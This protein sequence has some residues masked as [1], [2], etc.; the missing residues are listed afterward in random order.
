MVDTTWYGGYYTEP[1][2]QQT[3]QWATA[4]IPQAAYDPYAQHDVHLPYPPLD[5]YA[6]PTYEPYPA[7][8]Q[9]PQQEQYYGQPYAEQ[10]YPQQP[11]GEQHYAGQPYAEHPHPPYAEQAHY[12]AYPHEAP[13]A[14]LAYQ[15][16]PASGHD[17]DG[18]RA[19]HTEYADHAFDDD[20]THD[21]DPALDALAGVDADPDAEHAPA[22]HDPLPPRESA[23]PEDAV[24]G[25]PA[26]PGGRAAARAARSRPSRRRSTI[27]AIAVPSVALLGIAGAAAA[28]L[29]PISSA[30]TRPVA[31]GPSAADRKAQALAAAQATAAAQQASRD[32]ARQA[33][34]LSTAAAKKK[35][36]EAPR[37]VLPITEHTGLS[38]L[39]G[40]AGTHWMQLHTGID[41]PVSTGTEV[42]AVMD[43]VVSTKWNPFYGNM[44]M[45]TAS[46]GTVTWYC[47]LSAYRIRTGP[48]KAGD[49]VAYS[50][51]T[52][53]STGPHLHFEVHPNGGPAI[54]PLP[55][56]LS[57]GL[58]P[59]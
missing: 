39:F 40:Q 50:G 58:D 5:P 32:Q 54:D 59:R 43:G 15:P 38:A 19:D 28:G 12:G 44:L 33:L 18:D 25:E 24:T 23:D 35:A 26:V 21:P 55:W 10:Q 17:L 20:R 52:G 11:Y 37:Y 1:S 3:Q 45:V 42:H 49:I 14:E 41:F 48:V 13:F 30:H 8:Q 22:E 2:A 53:N 56:L 7:Y 51:D 16:E 29:A 9:H 6:T 27:L 4:P 57:H 36:A 47:H 31:S 46:D 34:A